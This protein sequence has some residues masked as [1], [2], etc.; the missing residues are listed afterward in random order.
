MF[1]SLDNNFLCLCF[2][3]QSEEYPSG[4]VEYSTQKTLVIITLLSRNVMSWCMQPSAPVH[5][6]R[7]RLF[8]MYDEPGLITLARNVYKKS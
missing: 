8:R 5:D 2:D 1:N 3:F 7:Y 6:R 4:C